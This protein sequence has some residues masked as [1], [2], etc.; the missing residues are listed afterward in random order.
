MVKK[1][2]EKEK[3]KKEG[4]EIGKLDGGVTLALFPHYV[5]GTRFSP[6]SKQ[7]RNTNKL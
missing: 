1:E 5:T 4:E 7:Y 6:C 2:E 3:G